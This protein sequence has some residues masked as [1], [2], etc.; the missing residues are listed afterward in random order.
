MLHKVRIR[1]PL[2]NDALKIVLARQ[3]EE[4]SPIALDVIAVEESF[5]SVGHNGPKA[6][7]AV[8]QR[9][10]TY[11]LAVAE[12]AALLL[13]I[14]PGMLVPKQIERI[15]ERLSTPEQQVAELR[16]AIGIEADD[17]AVENAPAALQ[18]AS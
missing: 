1:F 14:R 5:A 11:V 17:F 3:P 18:V 12:P 15:E 7:L 2:G 16:L 13:I 8:D 10:I 6:E 4:A 9:E